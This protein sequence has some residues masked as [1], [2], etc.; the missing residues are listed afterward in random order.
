MA[1]I[2]LSVYIHV[3]FCRS[4]CI[5]CDFLSFAG[6]EGRAGDYV[7]AL[8]ADICESGGKFLDYEIET[9][10]F[11]GGTPSLLSIRHLTDVLEMLGESFDIANDVHMSIE[12]NPDTVSEDYLKDLKNLGFNRISFGVQSFNNKLLKTIGRV[13]DAETAAW[14]VHAAANA[15]F[16]DINIDLIF[17]LP[18][19]DFSDFGESLD[20]ALSLPITH[21]SCYAL[22]VEE[23]TPLADAQ[24]ALLRDAMG[25]EDK[26][27]AMY[28][29]AKE[30]LEIAGFLHYETSSWARP[31]MECAH[32][33][34]Y[35]TGREYVGFGLGASSYFK[36]RRLKKTECIDSYINND[37]KFNILEELEAQAQM[38]E[39]VILGLRMTAGIDV[40]D[41]RTRFGHD[42]FDIFAGPLC[43]HLDDGLLVHKDYKIALTSKGIDLANTV[44]RGFL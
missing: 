3:P 16:D 26:D 5:Y 27:R 15:G 23:D 41:F 2:P 30:K 40:N 4:R 7:A 39:F 32:N 34:G 8:C 44:F 1:K 21:I 20:I 42:I 10:F 19:Q 25:D 18:H 17:N 12:S 14:A 35:W 6:C 38:A 36:N 22:T 37:F 11:G 9:V 28:A 29:L 13:H 31:G 43:K 33:V 24:C